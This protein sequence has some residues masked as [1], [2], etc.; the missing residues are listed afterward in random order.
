M[1]F[2]LRKNSPEILDRTLSAYLYG[3]IEYETMGITGIGTFSTFG[4]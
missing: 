2:L 4:P 3:F 1:T